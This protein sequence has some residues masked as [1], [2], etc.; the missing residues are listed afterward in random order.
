[1]KI[2][3][4]V[5]SCLLVEMP[6]PVNRTVLFDP[7][8]F[9]EEALPVDKLMYLD[10]IIITHEHFDH[11]SLPL[12]KRLV[13]KF[14]EVRITATASAVKQLAA[15]GVKADSVPPDGIAFFTAPHE[16][17]AP[18]APLPIAENN[19][20]HYLDKLSHPGDSH[21]FEET[22]AV[23][24]LP[25]TGPWGRSNDAAALAVKLKPRHVLPI[26]DWHWNDQAREQ[27]Y[28]RFEKFFT[29]NSINFHKLKTGEPVVLDV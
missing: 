28:D 1:M 3:K 4:Y 24:A 23:L 14:P 11:M 20:V 25:V 13:A 15:E 2:T 9:S 21:S 27:T 7:G 19:G 6:V 22:K 17:M 5:H 29:D 8:A 12:I 16:S 26:H 10:D 18:L